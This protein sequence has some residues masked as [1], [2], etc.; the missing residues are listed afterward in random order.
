MVGGVPHTRSGWG[1]TPSPG[2]GVPHL[3]VTGGTPCPDLGWGTLLVQ[4]WDGV[5]PLSR[6]GMGYPPVQT[7]D[8]VHPLSRPGMEYTPPS[9][10]WMEYPHQLDGVTSPKKLNRHTPVKTWPP[11]VRTTYAGGK[12]IFYVFL[13]TGI[14]SSHVKQDFWK[15]KNG[16]KFLHG[17]QWIKWMKLIFK[18]FMVN[19]ILQNNLIMTWISSFAGVSSLILSRIQ[20]EFNTKIYLHLQSVHKGFTFPQHAHTYKSVNR[21]WAT[22]NHCKM[23]FL[24]VAV[25]I[26]TSTH[27][28]LR[29]ISMD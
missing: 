16:V 12:Y 3:V 5:P 26:T 22:S 18:K 9:R 2:R 1:G 27:S 24:C 17:R 8:G 7:W 23:K 14:H 29:C 15:L 13:I 4:T 28:F 21:N 20:P 10:P 19:M 11:V 25:K 6:P